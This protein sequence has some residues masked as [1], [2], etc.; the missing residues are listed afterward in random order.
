MILGSHLLEYNS[1]FLDLINYLLL[2]RCFPNSNFLKLLLPTF[3]VFVYT[4]LTVRVEYGE[5]AKIDQCAQ[6]NIPFLLRNLLII[7]QFLNFYVPE[8]RNNF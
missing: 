5:E 7:I 1:I 4:Y 6:F 2:Y 8:P 3:L